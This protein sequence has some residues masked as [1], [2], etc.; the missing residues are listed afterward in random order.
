MKWISIEDSFPEKGTLCLVSR[1]YHGSRVLPAT[2]RY[3]GDSDWGCNSPVTHWMPAPPDP[4]EG[5]EW[6][7]P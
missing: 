4:E 2:K 5:L 7:T 1:F 6:T 3:H